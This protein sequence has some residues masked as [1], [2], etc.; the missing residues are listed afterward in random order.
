MEL[1]IARS[2]VDPRFGLM[3]KFPRGRDG[4]YSAHLRSRR[5]LAMLQSPGKKVGDEEGG[6]EKVGV[7]GWDQST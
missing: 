6:E 3:K 1:K 2:L 4:V 7:L 5:S